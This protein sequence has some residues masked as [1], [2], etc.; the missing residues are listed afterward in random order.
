MQASDWEDEESDYPLH[1]KYGYIRD[2]LVD[3]TKP[4]EQTFTNTTLPEQQNGNLSVALIV[5]DSLES[6]TQTSIGV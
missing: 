5:Y 2:E 1:Y 3:L 6:G 4:D